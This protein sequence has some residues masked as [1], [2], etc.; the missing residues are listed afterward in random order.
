MNINITQR[1]NTEWWTYAKI[2]F[3]G[4]MFIVTD[5]L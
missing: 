3:F 2:T 4:I 5:A 1:K